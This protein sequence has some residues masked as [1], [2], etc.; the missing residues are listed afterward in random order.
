ME[1]QEYLTFLS[2]L[3]QALDSLAG[4][5]DQK[6]AAVKAGDFEAL[7]RCMKQEQAAALDM[8]GREHKRSEMLR[9]LGLEKLPL[10]DLPA[11]CPEEYRAQAS[12]ITEQVLR[13]YE[14][15]SSAQTAARTLMENHLR[16]IQ[17]ELA[18]RQ[19]AQPEAAKQSGAPHKGPTDFR[20]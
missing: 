7:D 18:R 14:V 9:A 3:R 13:S 15:L 2:D 19:A 11:H 20:V 4:L 10:W 16:Q 5:Q 1:M 8:R 12:Q 6:I 17:Q